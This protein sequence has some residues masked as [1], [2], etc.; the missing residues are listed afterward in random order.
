VNLQAGCRIDA[1]VRVYANATN[2]L[3]QQRYQFYGG[4]VIGRR[5]L[6]GMTM[7]K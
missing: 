6:V 4:S 3:D 7:I 5:V 2:L 1:H